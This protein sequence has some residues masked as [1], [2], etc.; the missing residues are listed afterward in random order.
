MTYANSVVIEATALVL[1][2]LIWLTLLALGR[3]TMVDYAALV[4]DMVFIQNHVLVFQ[5]ESF[6]LYQLLTL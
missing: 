5:M 6:P 1:I 3:V 2:Y 4:M